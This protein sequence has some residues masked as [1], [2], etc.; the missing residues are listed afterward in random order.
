MFPNDM[1]EEQINEYFR[2]REAIEIGKRY[3]EA[4]ESGFTMKEAID[5][6]KKMP[7][8]WVY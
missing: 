5:I 3:M 1:T 7:L 2:I 8:P 4:R 6:A